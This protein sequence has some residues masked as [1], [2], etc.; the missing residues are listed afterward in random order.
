MC[1]LFAACIRDV[2]G[3]PF[4][5][6]QLFCENDFVGNAALGVPHHLHQRAANG[7]PYKAYSLTDK[8]A[9]NVPLCFVYRVC[10][11]LRTARGRPYILDTYNCICVRADDI[12]PYKAY[13]LTD[14]G[15]RNVPLR[16]VYRVCC[17]LRTAKGRP[18]KSFSILNSPFSILNSPFSIK[19]EDSPTLV[20]IGE[21]SLY[22]CR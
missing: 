21:S 16:F 2:G 1:A 5:T 11:Y 18:Y 4:P 10:C 14:K 8:G 6:F 22:K 17:Y 20:R 3:A 7:C 15:A 13:S 9:R 12:R 19:K